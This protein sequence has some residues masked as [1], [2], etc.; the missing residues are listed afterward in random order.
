MATPFIEGIPMVRFNT[1]MAMTT[2]IMTPITVLLRGCFIR[3]LHLLFAFRYFLL[4]FLVSWLRLGHVY[5]CPFAPVKGCTVF[6]M[7]ETRP[8]IPAVFGLI[9]QR[10]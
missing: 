3:Y 4:R 1:M 10:D 8:G 5:T 7:R 6:I 2:G 9:N